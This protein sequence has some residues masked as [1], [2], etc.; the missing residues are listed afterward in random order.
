MGFVT[1]R[2][3][4]ASAARCSSPEFVRGSG[5]HAFQI[6]LRHK[7][8]LKRTG[9]AKSSEA[10]IHSPNVGGGTAKAARGEAKEGTLVP[11]LVQRSAPFNK[12]T[13]HACWNV[14]SAP[15][16]H[17][18]PDPNLGAKTLLLQVRNDTLIT[19]Q[20][21]QGLLGNPHKH[22]CASQTSESTV[23]LY[24]GDRSRHPLQSAPKAD[25]PFSEA[26]SSTMR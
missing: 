21:N 1:L 9:R 3:V 13:K 14:L 7:P 5:L 25:E 19:R 22:R 18:S 24:D 11:Q 4:R 10:Y 2:L 23:K 17:Q 12:R 6:R 8:L 15:T 20:P 26:L 16:Q